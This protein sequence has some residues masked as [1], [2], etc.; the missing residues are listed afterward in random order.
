MRQDPG[1]MLAALVSGR[2]S[3]ARDEC[4]AFFI[5]RS[6][7]ESLQSGGWIEFVMGR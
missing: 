4:G 3:P 2:F 1:C 7:P 5:D 6:V